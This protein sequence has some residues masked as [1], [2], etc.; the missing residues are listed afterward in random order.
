MTEATCI[1][2]SVYR[3]A[4]SYGRSYRILEL[5]DNEQPHSI[6]L[7]GD[8]GRVRWYPAYCFDLSGRA[9]PRL[10]TVTIADDLASAEQRLIEVEL[11]F[12]DGQRRWCLFAA[13]AALESSGDYIDGTSIRL[14]YDMPH[15][16][17]AGILDEP[18]IKQALHQIERNGRIFSCSLAIDPKGE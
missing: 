3:G 6:K 4:L 5:D 7:Q 14:H 8:N 1:D 10:E 12:S 9:V 16:I 13:P 17:I 18:T 11:H 15:L 2:E